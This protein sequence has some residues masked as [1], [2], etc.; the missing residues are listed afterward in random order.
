MVAVLIATFGRAAGSPL[1]RKKAGTSPSEKW[2]LVL[3]T[4]HVAAFRLVRQATK[5]NKFYH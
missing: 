2:G 4:K 3:A 1:K 5:S